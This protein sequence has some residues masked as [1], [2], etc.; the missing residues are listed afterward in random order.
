[1]RALE[2]TAYR[3]GVLKKIPKEKKDPPP[4]REG[5]K[6]ATEDQKRNKSFRHNMTRIR[7]RRAGTVVFDAIASAVGLVTYPLGLATAPQGSQEAAPPALLARPPDARP[8]PLLPRLFLLIVLL[9]L[10][11]RQRLEPVHWGLG[12]APLESAVPAPAACLCL[13]SVLVRWTS[14]GTLIRLCIHQ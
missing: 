6:Q 1:M 3:M 7:Q 5:P 4:K 14:Q 9:L 12:L 2:N 13:W 8:A 10:P 11:L